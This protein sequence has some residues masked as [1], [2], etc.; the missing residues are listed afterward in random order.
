[1]C[2]MPT[3]ALRSF[4]G[5]P[6]RW[7]S[8]KAGGTGAKAPVLAEIRGTPSVGV[9]IGCGVRLQVAEGGRS[10]SRVF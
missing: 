1:M 8:T 6:K 5:G 3:T 9:E 2:R 10:R 4:Y 7:T